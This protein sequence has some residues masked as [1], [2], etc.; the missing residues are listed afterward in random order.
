MNEEE[1]MLE[2]ALE[3]L[4][5]DREEFINRRINHLNF[6]RTI[7]YLCVKYRKEDYVYASELATFLKISQARANQI[8][9]DFV[10]ADLLFK[11]PPICNL[12][13]YWATKKEGKIL[14]NNYF[15]KSRK[16]LGIK[17]KL[18]VKPGDQ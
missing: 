8:L 2:E 18:I 13:E 4:R 12:V 9:N 10:R 11:K 1:D 6:S 16:V 17:A 3:D 7:F 5:P 14:I 15:E